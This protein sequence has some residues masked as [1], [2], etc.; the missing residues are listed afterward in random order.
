MKILVGLAVLIACTIIPY[1]IGNSLS[2]S[3]ANDAFEEWFGGIVVLFVIFVVAC[4]C[5]GIGSAIL[6]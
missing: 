3:K 5:Y 1:L 4:I 2:I 6:S